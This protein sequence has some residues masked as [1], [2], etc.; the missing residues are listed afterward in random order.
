MLQSIGMT[1]RQ[2]QKTLVYEGIGYIA[3]SGAVSFVLGSLLSF[4]ILKALNSLI[5]FFEYRFQILP[6]VVMMPVL[7]MVAVLVPIL[8]F[9]SIR[10]QSIVERLREE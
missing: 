10:K 6:F 3:V 5:A 2:L 1:D 7:G 8:A 9:R 4:I